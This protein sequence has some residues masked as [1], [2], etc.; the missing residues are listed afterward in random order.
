MPFN[1]FEGNNSWGYNPDFYFA[2]DKYYGPENTLK[3]FIDSCHAKGIAVVMDIALNHSFGSSPLV[4]LY[5][6]AANNRP[7]ADNPWF[8]P[9][10][11]HALQCGL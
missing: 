8:N 9:V 11:K 10:A 3:Q 7:A 5:W 2:P 6:D 4:Q 1:E